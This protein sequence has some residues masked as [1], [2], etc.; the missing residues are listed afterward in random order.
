MLKGRVFT[1]TLPG[2]FEHGTTRLHWMLDVLC[3]KNAV[4]MAG[5]KAR[6]VKAWAESPG[7]VRKI[8]R[9]L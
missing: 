6:D 9:A 4:Q 5:L 1:S 3:R 2:A 7:R 8:T